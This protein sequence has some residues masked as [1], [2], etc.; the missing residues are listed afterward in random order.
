METPSLKSFVASIQLAGVTEELVD[1]AL[2]VFETNKIRVHLVR[3]V[4]LFVWHA[5]V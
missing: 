4:Y 3:E 2:N 1:E 5:L